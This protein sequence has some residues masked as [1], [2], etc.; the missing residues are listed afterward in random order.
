LSLK[1][2]QDV[3]SAVAREALRA[4]PSQSRWQVERRDNMTGAREAISTIWGIQHVIHCQRTILPPAVE[5]ELM[6]CVEQVADDDT[7]S[8]QASKVNDIGAQ[9]VT[10]L[11]GAR[12]VARERKG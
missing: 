4:L 10:Q 11:E 9:L 5:R 12:H 6:S 1:K 2:M 3:F 8:V 7:D